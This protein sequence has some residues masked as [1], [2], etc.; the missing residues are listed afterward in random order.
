MQNI[1]SIFSD[2]SKKSDFVRFIKENNSYFL[3]S[4]DKSGLKVSK[5]WKIKK[6]YETS[7]QPQPTQLKVEITPHYQEFIKF[8]TQFTQ[9]L[10]CLLKDQQNVENLLF[11]RQDT[12]QQEMMDNFQI[13]PIAENYKN[14]LI[15]QTDIDYEQRNQ[16]EEKIILENLIL[17]K[18]NYEYRASK[19]LQK[20]VENFQSLMIILMVEQGDFQVLFKNPQKLS[21]HQFK[22]LQFE[23]L[24]ILL[25]ETFHI[26]HGEFEKSRSLFEKIKFYLQ[27]QNLKLEAKHLEINLNF[28][29]TQN[30]NFKLYGDNYKFEGVYNMPAISSN[31]IYLQIYY[32]YEFY[33]KIAINLYP[34]LLIDH[35]RGKCVILEKPY[36]RIFQDQK[37][38]LNFQF[39]QPSDIDFDECVD[40]TPRQR[41]VLKEVGCKYYLEDSFRIEIQT[42]KIPSILDGAVCFIFDPKVNDLENLKEIMLEDQMIL[43]IAVFNKKKK[44]FRLKNSVSIIATDLFYN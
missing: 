5:S 33:S 44:K 30:L 23:K 24:R 37:M 41:D 29:D 4:V 15:Q 25:Q 1:S 12:T 31:Y 18:D 10:I 40:I 14:K 36:K 17:S 43:L 28:Q 21:I 3:C 35:Y 7:K 38:N 11:D 13:N 8:I 16:D 20:I 42:K 2:L 27:K 6:I 22:I 26:I 19:K 34:D 32:E 39:K 9:S